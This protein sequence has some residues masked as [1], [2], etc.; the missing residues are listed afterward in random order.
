MMQWFWGHYLT[1]TL[2]AAG[3][4][5]QR[6]C[7]IGMAHGFVRLREADHLTGRQLGT[8]FITA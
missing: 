3:V 6:H 1:D 7:W 5:I 2:M 8:R 4:P